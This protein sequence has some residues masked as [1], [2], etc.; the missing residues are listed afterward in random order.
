MLLSLKLL[1]QI[2]RL[3]QLLGDFLYEVFSNQENY[4]FYRIF[5]AVS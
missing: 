1:V 5:L 4:C 3:R 2:F